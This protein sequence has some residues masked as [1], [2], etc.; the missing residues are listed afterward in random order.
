[1]SFTDQCDVFGAVHEDGFNLV[2][3]HLM[4]QRPSLFNYATQALAD[5]PERLCEKVEAAQE[6]TD[7]GDPLVHVIEPIPIIGAAV[8][9]GLNWCLQFRRVAIDFHPGN[10]I[11][12]PPELGSLPEQRFALA[13][14]TC[15]GLQCLGRK[16]IVDLLPGIEAAAVA[17]RGRDDRRD[18]IVPPLRD[19]DMRCFCLGVYAI[20]HFEWG[21]IGSATTQWLKVR[22]DGLEIVDIQPRGLEDAIECYVADVL[23]LGLLPRL[24]TPIEKIVLDITKLLK[25]AGLAIG[26]QVSLVPTPLSATL[27]TNPAIEDDE[28]KAFADLVITPPL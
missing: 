5:H 22:I 1:M 26:H 17:K 23:Q 12:L 6:V 11:S 27:P 18:P 10:V 3:G 25:Q 28:L 8:P 24:S 20:G 16:V 19:R 9:V 2:V 15:A 13:L 14:Q 4:R 21:T 7:S